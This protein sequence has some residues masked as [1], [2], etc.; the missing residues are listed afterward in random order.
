MLTF[1]ATFGLAPGYGDHTAHAHDGLVADAVHEAIHRVQ[2]VSGVVVGCIVSDAR[3]FY[4]REFGCPAI[5][6]RVVVVSGAHNPK[7]CGV[8]SWRE[9]ATAVVELVKEF[10]KQERVTLTFSPAEVVYLEPSH[11]TPAREANETAATG[12]SEGEK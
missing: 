11:S 7:F 9:A 3:V 2:Q 8:D 5:G 1:S 10:L 6:E 4:P 12:S